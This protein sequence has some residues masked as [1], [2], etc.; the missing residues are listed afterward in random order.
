MRVGPRGL[1]GNVMERRK[2]RVIEEQ[3]GKWDGKMSADSMLKEGGVSARL[4]TTLCK[5]VKQVFT[6]GST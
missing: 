1:Y 5:V 2:E 6:P 3:K 4:G